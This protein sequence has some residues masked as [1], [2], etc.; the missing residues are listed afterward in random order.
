MLG[1]MARV[2]LSLLFFLAATGFAAEPDFR[3]K[4]HAQNFLTD[5]C[6]VFFNGLAP[7]PQVESLRFKDD[8]RPPIP[9]WLYTM[10]L[11]PKH[12]GP[13][14]LVIYVKGPLS[15]M[16]YL[17][18]L[19]PGQIERQPDGV[20]AI[21]MFDGQLQ[22]FEKNDGDAQA[23]IDHSDFAVAPHEA[24]QIRIVGDK[25]MFRSDI[26]SG[27]LLSVG[28]SVEH[29]S[30]DVDSGLAVAAA[31]GEKAREI[32]IHHTHP[33]V[34][35]L[36]VVVRP[37]TTANDP[38]PTSLSHNPINQ[39]DVTFAKNLSRKHP[40]I[41]VTT[42]VSVEP[43]TYSMTFLNGVQISPQKK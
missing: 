29:V 40:T 38:N 24:F 8:R 25:T 30:G 43:G 9:L 32:V 20:S 42:K 18:I 39:Q 11:G 26:I 1:G 17:E 3:Q 15:Y 10:A 7:P 34:T 41:P 33:A 19:A 22:H 2:A 37:G 6:R 35:Y 14:D 16:Q 21:G 5:M 27:S 13:E 4:P 31:R 23:L 36:H 28:N 12:F